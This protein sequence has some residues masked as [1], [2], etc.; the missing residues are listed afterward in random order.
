MKEKLKV[1][2]FLGR[3]PYL[4]ETFILRE[5]I[6][7]R[8]LGLDVHIFSMFP[9]LPTPVHTEVQEVMPYTHYSP[10]LISGR[11]ILAQFYFLLHAPYK[12]FRALSRAIW[13]TYREPLIL[14]RVLLIFPKTVY[15]A[16]EIQK[17]GIEH[18]H[19]HFVWVSGIAAGIAHDL[20]GVT[21][22]LHSHAFDLFAR[23]Q[24]NV[25]RQL[26]L[27][28]GVVTVSQYHRQY[29]R[30]LCPRLSLEDIRVV[31]YGVDLEEF[32]LAPI[33]AQNGRVRIISVG[34]LL[35][36]KGHEYLIEACARLAQQGYAFQC[37]IVGMGPR[38]DALQ[39]RIDNY[40]LHD[41]VF[42][43]GG[44][45]QDE[46]RELYRK[47]DLFVLACVVARGGD[48]DGMPNVLLEA[49]SM[50]IPV[51]TTA[52]TGIPELVRDRENGLLV[53]QRDALA[54]AGAIEQL[55]KDQTLRRRLAKEGRQTVL[56]EFDI[57]KTADQLASTF[58]EIHRSHSNGR[59]SR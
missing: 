52:V 1:A 7:L 29:I 2:Y 42:L 16:K 57:H 55:I 20:T 43:L 18:I 24:E 56:S 17:L 14:L 40:G 12:L 58:H 6:L 10:Y 30:N 34:S 26:A 44:K 46:I 22:S 49:M 54:L 47:S 27:A 48:R 3:F 39:A 11:L 5:I 41:C 59:T 37:L 25:S 53:P 36:K 15:F 31:H 50:Q 4:T 19:A 32:S 23:D 8:R 28:D 45:T 33:S 38:Q 35:E 51:I 9:P 13:Q 21:Y